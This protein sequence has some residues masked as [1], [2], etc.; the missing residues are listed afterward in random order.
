MSNPLS[1]KH[2]GPKSIDGAEFRRGGNKYFIMSRGPQNTVYAIRVDV[3][4]PSP[5]L[6]L[7]MPTLE[8]IDPATSVDPRELQGRE[9]I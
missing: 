3:P 9:E 6:V 8:E 4:E 5:L 7:S 2:K 1:I